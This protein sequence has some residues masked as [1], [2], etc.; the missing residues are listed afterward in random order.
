M[1]LL[2]RLSNRARIA[3]EVGL[4]PA[5]EPPIALKKMVSPTIRARQRAIPL[6]AA[7]EVTLRAALEADPNDVEAFRRLADIVRRRAAEGHGTAG[8]PDPQRAADDAVWSLAEEM[9]RNGRAWYPLV[10]LARLSLA[11]DRDG[12]LRRLGI[13]AERDHS[14]RA[15]A[16]AL[17]VLRDAGLSNEALGLGLGH[18]RPREHDPE[19]GRHLVHAAVDAG[20]ISEARRHLAAF[21]MYPDQ[22]RVAPVREELERTIERADDHSRFSRP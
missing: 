15:L 14:G 3:R 22:A 20:R 8:S 17:A 13:A 9:A 21:E 18:W 5:L 11:Q 2:E 16:E 19:A 1:G 10:E 4:R 6:A 12:A 7:E